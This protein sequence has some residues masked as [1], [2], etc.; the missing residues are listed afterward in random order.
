MP[1]KERLATIKQARK[2]AKVMKGASLVFCSSAA[3]VNVKK[4][5]KLVMQKVFGVDMKVKQMQGE[6]EPIIEYTM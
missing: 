3:G 1:E 6:N 2:F 5:F 4:I